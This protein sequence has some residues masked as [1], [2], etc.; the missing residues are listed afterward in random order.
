MPD[1]IILRSMDD[2]TTVCELKVLDSGK[3]QTLKKENENDY[4]E[5]GTVIKD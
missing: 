4:V 3:I 1:H 2:S 5:P